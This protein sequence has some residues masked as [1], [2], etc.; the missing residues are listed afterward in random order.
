MVLKVKCEWL[1]IIFLSACSV[2]TYYS[3]CQLHFHRLYG[4]IFVL[5]CVMTEEKNT[6][7]TATKSDGLLFPYYWKFD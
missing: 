4:F 2:T 3:D 7:T 6:T 1:S 5:L